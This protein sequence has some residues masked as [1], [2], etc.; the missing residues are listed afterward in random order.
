MLANCKKVSNRWSVLTSRSRS[1]QAND[2][3]MVDKRLST[4]KNILSYHLHCLCKFPSMNLVLD[5]SLDHT[6]KRLN[7][8]LLCK[9]NQLYYIPDEV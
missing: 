2:V 4:P 1:K 5:H 6:F 8:T 9:D 3:Y 7:M